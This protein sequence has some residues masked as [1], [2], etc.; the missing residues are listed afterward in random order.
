MIAISRAFGDFQFKD[1]PDLEPEYQAIT[2]VPDITQ[3]YRTDD[4]QYI[5]LACDGIWDQLSNDDCLKYLSDMI[6]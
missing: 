5:V 2:A 1:Q 6:N 3:T 4:D